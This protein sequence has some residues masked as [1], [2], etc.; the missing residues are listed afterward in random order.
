MGDV[1]Q[2]SAVVTE[3]GEGPVWSPWW[4]GLRLVDML[5]GEILTLL[6]G[7]EVRRIDVGRVAAVVR[8]RTAGGYV[9]GTEHGVGLAD[10]VDEPPTRHLRLTRAPGERMNEGTVTPD[11]SFLVGSSSWD[12][13]PGIASL[14][15]VA[16]DLTTERVLSDVTISNGVDF[17]P[18]HTRAYYV[19]SATGR[20]DVFD[21]VTGQLRNRRPLVRAPRESGDLDGL[22]VD[23]SG[24]IW[25]AVYGAGEVRR[26]GA[27]GSLLETIDVPV[28]HVTACTLG[29]ADLTE[30]YITTSR[31]VDGDQAVP[32]AGAIFRTRVE[33]PGLPVRAFAG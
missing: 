4:G 5:R 1:E 15:R 23:S 9:V 20:L 2:I 32:G 33:V 14:Y 26:Y 28:P 22:V 6:N 29:G 11:G 3:H 25:V 31:L 10:D 13:T 30:L 16:P 19:D 18:D 8:P 7:G 21:V 24:A 12:V 27:D 17:S